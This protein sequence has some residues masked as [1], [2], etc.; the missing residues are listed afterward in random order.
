MRTSAPHAR[1][2]AIGTALA[3]A[4]GVTVTLGAGCDASARSGDDASVSADASVV[5]GAVAD[6]TATTD[7]SPTPDLAISLNGWVEEI[8]PH[9]LFSSGQLVADPFTPRRLMLVGVATGIDPV[10]GTPWADGLLYNGI[11][12][13]SG[14]VQVSSNGA[15]TSDGS[16]RGFLLSSLSDQSVT[17]YRV[18][19]GTKGF[20][21]TPYASWW[22]TTMLPPG[23]GSWPPGDLL[24]DRAHAVSYFVWSAK[25][26]LWKVPEIVG[27][28][29]ENAFLPSTASGRLVGFTAD[30]NHLLLAGA[31]TLQRCAYPAPSDCTFAPM[32]GFV[33]GDQLDS[34][35][36]ISPVT[37]DVLR[38]S[39]RNPTTFTQR[40]YATS[41]SGATLT[42]V[43]LPV[44]ATGDMLIV[45]PND[46]DTM[47]VELSP[48]NGLELVAVTHDRGVTWKTTPLPE[49][50]T[51]GVVL[52]YDAA[53]TLF[54]LR[55]LQLFS[56]PAF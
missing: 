44:G 17:T 40:A 26:K 38:M 24:V 28:P 29:V 22:P 50:P 13:P 41:D 34:P 31:A 7:G 6:A 39:A 56:L 52:V 42:E 47:A 9:R 55:N 48:T 1:Q 16:Y 49:T 51:G 43:P 18:T 14:S 25:H 36:W 4:L 23:L 8:P 54:L 30:G 12:I 15:W 27:G 5:D 19:L 33:A 11:P 53:G 3:V 21:Q 45:A 20:S 32:A 10:L 37:N 46:A 35:L 2:A